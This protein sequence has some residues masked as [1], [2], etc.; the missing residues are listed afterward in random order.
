[1]AYFHTNYDASTMTVS[2]NDEEVSRALGVLS[3][4]TPAALKVAVNTTARQTRKLML[5]F[6]KLMPRGK[7]K[8]VQAAV[9]KGMDNSE[10][11]DEV[12]KQLE[13]HTLKFAAPY[14]YKGSEKA[15]LKDKTFDSIDLSGVGELNTMSE[16]MAENRMAAGGFAPVNTH[17]NY[18]YCCIIASMGTGY[19]VD[20][21]AG[22]P[23]CE[24]VK[25]RDAVNSDFFE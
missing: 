19:P 18:L 3:N 11:A 20:F 23:L 17:R 16:S 21:F 15:E 6:F 10:N 25:L 9:V 24:A 1:M 2:V 13:S 8:K 4:K 22:L 7:I 12:K 5:E 14:T